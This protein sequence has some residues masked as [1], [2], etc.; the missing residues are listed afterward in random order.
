VTPA[1]HTVYAPPDISAA[2]RD[3]FLAAL[4][5]PCPAARGVAVAAARGRRS[6]AELAVLAA[7]E[8]PADE[9]LKL[10]AT[11][12]SG[13][14][15][16]ELLSLTG[17]IENGAILTRTSTNVR[18]ATFRRLAELVADGVRGPVT[19][20]P[21][22][23]RDLANQPA[24]VR[25]AFASLLPPM[26]E[27][28]AIA[29][30]YLLA[31]RHAAGDGFHRAALGVAAGPAS[32]RR[33]AVVDRFDT[34]F[35][36]WTPAA[37]DLAAELLPPSAADRATKAL[38]EPGVGSDAKVRAVDVLA[39]H[40]DRASAAAILGQ[41]STG[42]PEGRTRAVELTAERLPKRWR[43]L[44]AEPAFR[45]AVEKLLASASETDR[46]AGL[47]LAGA[48]DLRSDIEAVSKL[49]TDPAVPATVRADAVRALGRMSDPKVVETLAK[50]LSDATTG[51]DTARALGERL[52]RYGLKPDGAGAALRAVVENATAPREVRTAA[53]AA[54][55]E[56]RAGC[57]WLLKS[58]HSSRL[59]AGVDPLPALRDAPFAEVR[60]AAA[61]LPSVSR[62]P[63]P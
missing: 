39:A 17:V 27:P 36:T 43:W 48:A 8:Q 20:P 22:L 42:S 18:S 54:L 62:E 19:I 13:L 60:A 57:E 31:R 2:G 9:L 4:V 23:R 26:N 35:P 55:A 30:Y 51:P 21:A 37:A 33:K 49:A 40:G 24:G 14:S 1:G 44:A 7:R 61:R 6:V 28:D 29:M 47:R 46:V 12:V 45:D 25:V 38:A 58:A 32:D 59:P 63:R 56:T 50:Q 41:V 11:A 5:S 10:R 16:A 15:S 34:F 3:E 52:A 53:V